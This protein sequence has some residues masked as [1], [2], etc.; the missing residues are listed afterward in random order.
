L[1]QIDCAGL[2]RFTES[3]LPPE[4]IL[5]FF[6]L[7]DE[8]FVWDRPQSGEAQAAT[9]VLYSAAGA[10][11][12]ERSAPATLPALYGGSD[13]RYRKPQWLGD[14]AFDRAPGQTVLPKNTMRSVETVSFPDAFAFG[15]Y[16]EPC[17]QYRKLADS[18]LVA[19]LAEK[20]ISIADA[21]GRLL[22]HQML[23][24]PAWMQGAED[25]HESKILLLQLDS[26]HLME[27]LWADVGMAQ[28]W[29]D[30]ADLASCRFGR[31]FATLGSS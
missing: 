28:F 22:K 30:P 3:Y 23:G 2:P 14:W 1:A 12:P 21:T 20:D 7:M 29:I 4:G 11:A 27:W 19:D 8:D 18:R 17:R 31:A 26:D 16:N 10:G 5:Y 9:R 15:I 13:Y 6:A 24:A 25:L